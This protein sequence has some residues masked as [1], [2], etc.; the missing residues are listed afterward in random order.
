MLRI[1]SGMGL[2]TRGMAATVVPKVMVQGDMEHRLGKDLPGITKEQSDALSDQAVFLSQ[3]INNGRSER[4]FPALLGFYAPNFVSKIAP[5]KFA[6]PAARFYSN[7]IL[8][9]TIYAMPVLTHLE[10]YEAQTNNYRQYVGLKF[11]YTDGF[12]TFSMTRPIG[13]ESLVPDSML[14]DS[15][16]EAL[17]K[18]KEAQEQALAKVK[19]EAAAKQSQKSSPIR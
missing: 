7:S 1:G 16:K 12:G 6:L 8:P 13:S 9:V 14:T 11:Q 19:A 17:A 18:D 3:G 10:K 15:Q 4:Q 2:V 5:L